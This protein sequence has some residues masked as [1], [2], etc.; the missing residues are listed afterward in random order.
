MNELQSIIEQAWE[1]RA[2]LQE[3]KTTRAIREVIELLDAGTL[4]VAEPI[5]DGWLGIVRM[6]RLSRFSATDKAGRWLDDAHLHCA[7]K[8]SVRPNF[9]RLLCRHLA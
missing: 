2:L 4:R 9:L 7:A 1:N 3:E 6:M 8:R 5:N